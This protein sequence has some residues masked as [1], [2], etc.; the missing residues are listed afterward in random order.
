MSLK[1]DAKAFLQLHLYLAVH[2][3]GNIVSKAKF[4]LMDENKVLMEQMTT[5][6]PPHLGL[7][8]DGVSYA[9]VIVYC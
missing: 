9:V 1:G 2:D 8:M 3:D 4:Q 6:L 5:S 7:R